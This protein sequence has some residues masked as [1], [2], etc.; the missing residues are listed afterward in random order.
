MCASSHNREVPDFGTVLIRHRI[1]ELLHHAGKR[2]TVLTGPSGSGK[3]IA[4][5]IHAARAPEA[6]IWVDA[7]G[8][9]LPPARLAELVLA[10]MGG[11]S[12]VS[13]ASV[14]TDLRLVGLI[15]RL[16]RPEASGGLGSQPHCVVLDD[17][18]PLESDE[19]ANEFA[20]LLLALWRLRCQVVV[21]TRSLDRWPPHLLRESTILGQDELRLTA[22]EAPA[23]LDV[24][25]ASAARAQCRELL[26]ACDGNI[27][28]FAVLSSQA[29]EDEGGH[30]T[31]RT[32][33]LDAWI[34][35]SI[36]S[37]LSD[38]EVETLAAASLLRTGKPRDLEVLG[39]PDSEESLSRIGALIPL[40]TIG[41]R[42][43]GGARF[44]IHDLLESYCAEH[45][46]GLRRE[47]FA[48]SRIGL[49]NLLAERGDYARSC[50]LLRQFG[51]TDA[52]L[53]WAE[54]CGRVTLRTGH[55]V[56]LARLV[57]A[58]PMSGIMG[59]PA[60][61]LVAAELDALTGSTEDALAKSRAA[62]S[63][64]AHSGDTKTES[65]ALSQYLECLYQL[66]R[67]DEA[68]DI[69][70]TVVCA[71]DP[72]DDGL[73]AQAFLVMG[74]SELLRG[75]LELAREYLYSAQSCAARASES[76]DVAT[77]AE[78]AMALLPALLL[79]DFVTTGRMLA[80]LTIQRGASSGLV[81]VLK[82]NM[83]VALVESGRAVRA[84]HLLESVLSHVGIHG[85]TLLQGAYLPVLGCA[86]IA[87]GELELGV[88]DIQSGISNS[89]DAGDQCS[90]D[91]ARVYLAVALRAGGECDGALS[92]AEMA[93]ERLSIQDTFSF[94][95]LAA[96]EIAAS[97]LALGDPAAA[98]SWAGTVV[99][100]GFNGNRYHALRADMILAEIE[101]RDGDVSGAV[102]RLA[103][104]RDHIVS[105][106]SNWQIAMYCRA[107][108]ELLGLF[109]LAV[110]ADRLPVHMLRMI[111]PEHAERSL[112]LTRPFLDD[113]TWRLLGERLLG[114]EELV[115]LVAREGLPLC[116]VRVFG[117][118]EVSIGGRTVRERDWKKRKARL[119][120]AMLVTRRG[121]D[122]P[123]DTVFEYLWPELDEE[124]AKNNLYV[125]WSTMKSVLVGPGQKGPCP[126]V[127][128]V[129]GVCRTVRTN[130]RAD[131]DEFEAALVRAREA[132]TAGNAREA[133][134][135]Y[136]KVGDLYRG[137]LLPGDCY[138]DWFSVMRDHYR[139]Q[140]V[141]A[142]LRATQLL[143]DADDP[144][145][146]LTFVRRAIQSDPFRED[147][148]QC[149]LRC[150]IA[151]G[152][153]SSAIDTYFQLRSKLA[154]ELGLDPSAETRALYDQI[155]AMED[156]P[157]PTP[158]DPMVD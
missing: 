107:F 125:A 138:D 157:R 20:D 9:S 87:A 127:E 98:R 51:S 14:A 7:C 28:L 40:A 5:A 49:L 21:T 76:A 52:I 38:D 11:A 74:R 57:E 134:T 16:T 60:V 30:A 152:Q 37:Q 132:E 31:R 100:E 103:S 45:L 10:A 154:D 12:E 96:L 53:D 137:D 82:G 128:S 73:V 158:L 17:I 46:S 13:S 119:L 36:G 71:S 75:N 8:E 117:G 146:A 111:L 72:V 32:A 145:N 77:A 26:E 44:R 1:T 148:Y 113:A 155:L 102:D 4:A 147:L 139:T 86:R 35:T 136:E 56:A 6:A 116:H 135:A 25:G 122:V 121:Q 150:Q 91:Q 2:P 80:P 92:C 68:T 3:S 81:P 110:G 67:T 62:R 88:A 120:F 131:V 144:G 90:V 24:L 27:A 41:G 99:D 143:N 149:A 123:R 126:Y 83:A 33:S 47:L 64:A 151:A 108:P 112:F 23:L 70:R 58:L 42:R 140:F 34:S 55:Y 84:T 63:L 15:D 61:L 109:A 153:R 141:D 115:R 130:V 22:G 59:R 43:E 18:G 105:E 29:K 94:R 54:S 133:L 106:N 79:G 114:E 19:R 39:M 118:L 97:L 95:R 104:A 48:S 142:M 85:Q 124:R 89:I 156:R 129:G 69:A 65:Q 101:R 66:G 93:Y 50:E 78:Q